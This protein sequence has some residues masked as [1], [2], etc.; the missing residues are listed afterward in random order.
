MNSAQDTI[1]DDFNDDLISRHVD[2]FV[3]DVDGYEGP[4]DI[5]LSLA[6]DQKVDITQISILQLAN[7]YLAFVMEVRERN[8]ELAADYLVMAAWLAYLKSKLLLP[9]LDDEDQPTGSELAAVLAFQLK[10]LEAM[11]QAGE[12]LTNTKLLGRDFFARGEP[13]IFSVTLN[14]V[15]DASLHDLMRAYGDM[16]RRQAPKSMTI[17]AVEL[18]TVDL[19]LGRIRRMLGS[20][21]EW[22]ELWQFLPTDISNPLIRRSAIASTFTA[23][24]ELAREGKLDIRQ[25]GVF[26]QIYI[27]AKEETEEEA[28]TSDTTTDNTN[29]D[30]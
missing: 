6:R 21:P 14:T 24:L 8:L 18:Y 19:A 9:D 3:V 27:S 28:G 2:A 23:T 20:T 15:L 16:K 12:K 13:E 11:Q 22:K 7:Q 1:Q 4:L 26:G 30:S 25:S 5:L 17:E 10:R 29:E